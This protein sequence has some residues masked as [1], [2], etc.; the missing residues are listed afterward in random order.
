MLVADGYATT[1]LAA[2]A[3]DAGVSVEALYK[4][5]KNKAGIVKALFDV[6]VAGDDE[7][8]P[9]MD[10]SWVAAIRAEPGAAGSWMYAERLAPSMARAT[11]RSCCSPA[12]RG[13]SMPRWPP[14]GS[15][16]PNASR[17]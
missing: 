7:P 4:A 9:I 1:T 17:A 6:A 5:F 12:R 10:R 13:R 8:V 2:V 3:A 15:C 14:S 11:P 16:R